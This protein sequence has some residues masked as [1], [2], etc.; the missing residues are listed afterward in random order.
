M[1]TLATIHSKALAAA[2]TC[3]A[4]NDVREYLN[5]IFLEPVK[6]GGVRAVATNGHTM[7][8]VTDPDGTCEAPVIVSLESTAVTKMRQKSA[9]KVGIKKVDDNTIIA[10]VHGVSPNHI[11]NVR[12]ID[13]KYPDWKA[14]VPK[15]LPAKSAQT[16]AFNH[17]YMRDFSDAAKHLGASH[18]TLAFVYGAANHD[19]ICV[20]L[21]KP[22][23]G[24]QAQGVL[25][26]L[27]YDDLRLS[28][29]PPG[30]KA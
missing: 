11:S 12:L 2:F 5:G 1:K 14:V 8:M 18:D 30:D 22:S 10:D 28:W 24:L 13:G 29:K 21:G 23:Y 15:K 26:P 9:E 17:L 3:Q 7:I 27:R 4:K 20:L 25:M 19:P 16:V 6:S